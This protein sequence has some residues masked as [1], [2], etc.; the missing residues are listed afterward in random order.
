MNIIPGNILGLIISTL[1]EEELWQIFQ[2][3]YGI[4]KG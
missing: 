3:F 1:A 4:T 2:L